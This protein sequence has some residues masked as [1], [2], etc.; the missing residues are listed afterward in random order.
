M[1][2]RA[3]ALPLWP[4]VKRRLTKQGVKNVDRV[5]L[6]L[7]RGLIVKNINEPGGL[8]HIVDQA[9]H[10][11]I[12]NTRGYTELCDVL[13]R[14]MI[15]HT[16][17][18]S[19][20]DP[21]VIQSRIDQTVINYR[22]RYHEEPQDPNWETPLD[23]VTPSVVYVKTITGQTIVVPM[24][25]SLSVLGLKQRIRNQEGIPIDQQLLIF[26]GKTLEAERTLADYNIQRESTL[27][28]VMNLRG[29]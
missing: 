23:I 7:V 22:K 6:E 8:P 15:H 3:L 19:Q 21:V 20:D 29:C 28:L 25:G 26:A 5:C 17:A 18:S 27:H 24:E 12:L 9:W 4:E 1:E 14:G 16:T 13:G 2:E 10:E 11:A